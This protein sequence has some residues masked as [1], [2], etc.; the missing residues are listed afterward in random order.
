MVDPPDGLKAMSQEI[1]LSRE[2]DQ[3]ISVVSS[4]AADDSADA[5][6]RVAQHDYFAPW[7]PHL[8]MVRVWPNL[9]RKHR[10][11]IACFVYTKP[12]KCRPSVPLFTPKLLPS[13]SFGQS[14]AGELLSSK[15]LLDL[16]AHLVQAL[17]RWPQAVIHFDS[18]H[19]QRFDL[20]HDGVDPELVE[21]FLISELEQ[22][23]KKFAPSRAEF[24][25]YTVVKIKPGR[26]EGGRR[27]VD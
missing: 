10:W 21:P 18:D 26:N 22:A 15:A 19:P 1:G 20:T 5:I 4:Y 3:P 25:G 17:F 13:A 7:P 24:T 23:L 16:G 2:S 12:R 11:R 14:E 27:D 8:L 6:G 9:D